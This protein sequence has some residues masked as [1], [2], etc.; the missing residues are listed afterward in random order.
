MRC[1]AHAKYRSGNRT[2]A[3]SAMSPL[4]KAQGRSLFSLSARLRT[5]AGLARGHAAFPRLA[6]RRQQKQKA[7]AY[8]SRAEYL[9]FTSAVLPS[10]RIEQSAE[11]PVDDTD[12]MKMQPAN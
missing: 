6:S 7:F 11:R 5:P 4:K 1:D 12:G 3:G 8:I 9:F 10:S 2:E